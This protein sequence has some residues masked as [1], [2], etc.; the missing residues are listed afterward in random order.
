MFLSLFLSLTTVGLFV[1]TSRAQA[2]EAPVPTQPGTAVDGGSSGAPPGAP[3]PTGTTGTPAPLDTSA[4]VDTAAP[5]GTLA[6]EETPPTVIVDPNAADPNAPSTSDAVPTT[7]TMVAPTTTTTLGPREVPPEF[8]SK[9]NSV[10]RSAA[11]D[12]SDL[13]ALLAPLVRAGM[14]PREVVNIGYG[15]FPVGGQ[16]N[17]WH[18]W[19]MP[20][21]TPAFH[22]HQGTDVFAAMGVPL[23][24]PVDGVFTRR[25]GGAGGIGARV[26]QP[27]GTYFY[28]AH[29]ESWVDGLEDGTPVEQGDIIGYV[30]DTGNADG[31]TPHLHFQWHPKG[32]GPVDP[33]PLL[34][35]WLQ[36]AIDD[37]PRLVA[38]KLAELTG[39]PMSTN[40]VVAMFAR[41]RSLSSV[42]RPVAKLNDL[43]FDPTL[44][45]HVPDA[46]LRLVAAETPRVAPA[47]PD[48]SIGAQKARAA[49]DDL[50]DGVIGP[51][52]FGLRWQ[53]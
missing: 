18:D 51:R 52:P 1:G 23:R 34:D 43:S 21:F 31:G 37:A 38:V 29:L 14:D 40:R 36:S 10:R 16:A 2:Q 22:L 32:G 35:E 41:T 8:V 45:D 48:A 49:F 9:I 46:T 50:L 13:V 27:D 25:S 6:P 42:D 17:Y 28:F 26:T 11:H 30:G 15:Q 53:W 7:T 5:V 24:A 12:T 47:D 44:G 4:P 19:W 33:K 39:E 20:R 3:A